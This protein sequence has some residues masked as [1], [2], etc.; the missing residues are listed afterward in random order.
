MSKQTKLSFFSKPTPAPAAAPAQTLAEKQDTKVETAVK[1]DAVAAPLPVKELAAPV[2]DNDLKEDSGRITT[3]K[4]KK[5]SKRKNV[6]DSESSGDEAMV[7]R[8]VEAPVT[9][10]NGKRTVA[11]IKTDSTLHDVSDSDRSASPPAKVAKKEKVVSAEV[12]PVV[13][14]PAATTATSTASIPPASTNGWVAGQP[15][16]FSHLTRAY[17][18]ISQESGRLKTTD[19]LSQCFKQIL[20]N[21]P[22]DLLPS[23]YVTVGAIAPAHE[24]L[25]LGV[26]SALL[27]KAISEAYAISND[28]LKSEFDALGD[29]GDVVQRAGRAGGTQRT[30]IKP[31]RL[32]LRSVFDTFKK[33]AHE[34]GK[35]SQ[36]TRKKHIQSMLSAC[37]FDAYEPMFLVR[38]LEG[39]LRIGCAAQTV[40]DALADACGLDKEDVKKAYNEC[41]SFDVIVPVL[42]EMLQE[43]KDGHSLKE[44]K[45][46]SERVSITPGVPVKPMLA[47]PSNMAEVSLKCGA[48]EDTK[49]VT[50]EYKYDGERAQ[51]HLTDK[52]EVHIYS[53]NAEN[54]TAKFPEV[55]D[56][57]RKQLSQGDKRSFIIDAEIV[58]IGENNKILPF[59]T[60]STRARKNVDESE[61]QRVRV[62]VFAFDL[63]YLNGSAL[64]AQSLTE[65]RALL[66]EQ[67]PVIPGTFGHAEHEDMDCTDGDEMAVFFK[68]ALEANCEG[69]MVKVLKDP[70]EPGKRSA[71]W[72]KLKK[73]YEKGLT[74]SL[75]LV[76]IGAYTGKGKRTGLYGAYLLACYDPN[77][78]EYQSI[79]KIGTGF[80]EEDLAKF[81]EMLSKY[82]IPHK[83]TYFSIP[84]KP[85]LVPD[86]YFDPKVVWE[87]LA[88]DL[89]LSPVHRAAFGRLQ[90]D[91]GIALRFPRFIR[92]RED[93][94]ATDATS[95]ETVVDMYRNQAAVK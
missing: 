14:V 53:R 73:D 37:Q 48:S 4:D 36:A 13:S 50:C 33:I 77:T 42:L 22:H 59:Q 64:I 20:E 6:I 90:D 91:R 15:T 55:A 46:L 3:V 69:L 81:H 78:E 63:M 9:A 38:A 23:L 47:K 83:P 40:L 18:A 19:I 67:F 95:A 11:D 51:L 31:T 84:D 56:I 79:C 24:G 12:P 88:A 89:S 71:G 16:P 49:L 32:T 26:G 45:P 43:Q 17:Y 65:R 70:Y 29:W 39:N 82:A 57:I 27:Q 61:A 54:H 87:V 25:E 5:Q 74:D 44:M 52:G 76:P 7:S 34:S 1:R 92:V 94:D 8:S 66:Q 28:K 2:S 72:F 86:V 93:K 35:N 75:D 80:S 10:V 62:A 58:A 68:K 21:A 41:P 30:L 85:D 60:L